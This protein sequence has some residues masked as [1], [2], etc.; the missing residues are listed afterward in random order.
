VRLQLGLP[1]WGAPSSVPNRSPAQ[2]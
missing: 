1:R 2:G